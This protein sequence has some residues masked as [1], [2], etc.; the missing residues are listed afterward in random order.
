MSIL[1]YLSEVS[2]IFFQTIDE[3]KQNLTSTKRELEFANAKE[4]KAKK[5]DQVQMQDIKNLEG[6]I[7][8]KDTKLGQVIII[9]LFV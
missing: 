1:P 9:E 3:L 2:N 5:K 6:S 7:A 4:I 8:E